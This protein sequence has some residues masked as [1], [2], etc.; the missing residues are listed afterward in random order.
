MEPVDVPCTRGAAGG[1]AL[2]GR[3]GEKMVVIRHVSGAANIYHVSTVQGG[4]ERVNDDIIC[5][6]LILS[7]R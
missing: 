2:S 1:S 7:C 5:L 6:Y 4:S 3:C